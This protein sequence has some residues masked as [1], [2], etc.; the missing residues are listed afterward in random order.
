[1]RIREIKF[2]FQSNDDLTLPARLP[3]LTGLKIPPRDKQSL[4][5]RRVSLTDRKLKL[6]YE[7]CPVETLFF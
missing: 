6:P 2:N 1:M 3:A 5:N 4:L 7:H